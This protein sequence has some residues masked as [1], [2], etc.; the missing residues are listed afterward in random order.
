MHPPPPFPPPF[1][2]AVRYEEALAA[3]G[4]LLIGGGAGG[5]V[6][7]RPGDAEVVKVVDGDVC[8]HAFVSFVLGNPSACLPTLTLEH[9]DAINLRG[10]GAH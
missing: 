9:W 6:Y 10:R 5:R 4:W 7:H 1:G 2:S 3:A 8:Y